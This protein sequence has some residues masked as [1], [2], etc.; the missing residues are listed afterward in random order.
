MNFEHISVESAKK[1]LNKPIA[2]HPINSKITGSVSS[3][4]LLSQIWYWWN[5]MGGKEFYKKDEEFIAET[6]LGSKEFRNAKNKLISL[7]IL[8]AKAKGVPPKTHYILHEKIYFKLISEFDKKDR[9]IEGKFNFAL[10]AKLNFPESKNK[11]IQKGKIFNTTENTTENTIPPIISPEGGE[12]DGALKD[13]EGLTEKH[14]SETSTKESFETFWSIYP[15]KIGKENAY[16]QFE[17]NLRKKY[18]FE[19]MLNSAKLYSAYCQKRRLEPSYIKT[20][21]AFLKNIWNDE[22][23][24]KEWELSLSKPEDTKVPFSRMPSDAA[25]RLRKLIAT[26]QLFDEHG[27]PITERTGFVE[28][29]LN[30]GHWNSL[31]GFVQKAIVKFQSAVETKANAVPEPTGWREHL[32]QN[33]DPENET[34]QRYLLK[35]WKSIPEWL[36]RDI[37]F[38]MGSSAKG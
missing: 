32:K 26:K 16:K 30:S 21:V 3:G 12:S 1:L 7:G 13:E 9:E 14:S 24:L 28:E 29:F 11:N 20:P 25:Q 35:G 10:S 23:S 19:E 18:N 6:T 22:G 38:E 34:L 17:A 2:F 15:R 31:P 4:V 5:A 36:Q 8:T 37:V 27:N 33:Y